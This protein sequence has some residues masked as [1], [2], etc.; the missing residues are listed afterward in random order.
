MYVYLALCVSL[1]VVLRYFN[2]I[3]AHPSGEIGEL[4]IG[5]PNNLVP[6]VTQTGA[7]LREKL[8]VFG[9][10]YATPDGSAVRD[11]IHVVDLAKAHVQALRWLEAQDGAGFNEFI[12][13][14]TG[15]GQSVLEVITAF[16]QASGKKLNWEF[17]PRR[18]GDI[19]QIW[20]DNQKAEQVLGWKATI[21]VAESMRDAWL[22]QQ[23]LS[24]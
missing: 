24:K 3:G 5:V 4:P 14:G 6:Y 8:T 7:G 11:Y 23:R 16:E 21:G 2:P 9:N 1:Q 20:A 15:I 22:W 18:D 17:G 19:E 13:L 12:N 10:D